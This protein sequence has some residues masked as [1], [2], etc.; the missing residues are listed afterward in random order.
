LIQKFASHGQCQFTL[1][2]NIIIID[3]EGPWNV[4]FFK[5]MHANL[6][7]VVLENF[8]NIN[9]GIIV[10]LKGETLA[11]QEGLDY[12]LYKVKHGTAKAIAINMIHS[13]FA[14]TTQLEFEAVYNKAG[15]KNKFFNNTST[16][17]H[18]LESELVSL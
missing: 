16:A 14:L 10:I 4:E 7:Q 2:N 9:Y 17:K 5:Q 13:S 11:T 1:D 15:I 12:H 6:Q 18:W 3:A 8:I